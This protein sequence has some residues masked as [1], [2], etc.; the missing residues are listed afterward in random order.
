[1][2]LKLESCKRPKQ[3]LTLGMLFLRLCLLFQSLTALLSASVLAGVLSSFWG[4]VV[5]CMG[6]HG[7]TRV[8]LRLRMHERQW[9]SFA[10]SSIHGV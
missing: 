3:K 9:P 4:F 1:M 6:Y 7:I 10:N 5:A 2:L 8:C